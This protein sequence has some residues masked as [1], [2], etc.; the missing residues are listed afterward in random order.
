MNLVWMGPRRNEVEFVVALMPGRFD[1]PFEAW[2][3]RFDRAVNMGAGVVAMTETTNVAYRKNPKL[4][5]RLVLP[6]GWASKR[7]PEVGL[8]NCSLA[9]SPAVWEFCESD[10]VQLEDEPEWSKGGQKRPETYALRVAL[11]NKASGVVTVFVV[12]H[13]PLENTPRRRAA[14]AEA[15][16]NMVGI[17]APMRQKFGGSEATD[18]VLA[19][20]WNM[21]ASDE[22][23]RDQWIKMFPGK[24]ASWF[25]EKVF[26]WHVDWT[27]TNPRLELIAQVKVR[28]RR[29]DA[30]DHPMQLF[31]Y[32]R[33]V[34]S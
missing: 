28:R 27:A 26:G 16:E 4:V 21:R 3:R 6:N 18:V 32:R 24:V 34:A 30:L 7:Y 25:G 10:T 11:R 15:L 20:D 31:A 12:A 33:K 19:L 17:A 22:S 9:Y 1:A 5:E 29:G 8:N 14:K 13:L 23:V 2:Q